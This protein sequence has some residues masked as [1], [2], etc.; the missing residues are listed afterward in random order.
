MCPDDLIWSNLSF[1]SY[2][3]RFTLPDHGAAGHSIGYSDNFY[4]PLQRYTL[5]QF[6]SIMCWRNFAA[7][8]CSNVQPDSSINWSA[9]R[10]HITH[11]Q[12]QSPHKADQRWTLSC[13][14]ALKHLLFTKF[15]ITCIFVFDKVLFIKTL[16]SFKI[17]EQ[18]LPK[19]LH[20]PSRQ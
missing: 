4:M 13:S 12:H 17:P 1:A 14:T 7:A 16:V 10:L 8:G 5:S 19:M 18:L 2:E 11:L 9:V 3:T 15:Q 20:L 6:P